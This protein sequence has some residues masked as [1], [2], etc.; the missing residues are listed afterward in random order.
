MNTTFYF[1]LCQIGAEKAVKAE[2]IDEYP[3]LRFCFSR[4]GFI[5]FK[6]SAENAAEIVLKKN[7]FTRLWGKVIGKAS[8]PEEL[9]QLLKEIPSDADVHFFDRDMYIPGEEPEGWSRSANIS[10][11]TDTSA[12]TAARGNL[13]EPTNI[14]N[15]R[16]L[17][18]GVPDT[19]A[20]TAAGAK[21]LPVNK[22]RRIYDVIFIDDFLV[23]AGSHIVT[24]KVIAEPANIPPLELPASSPSRA[25]LKL[26]EA[27]YRFKPELPPFADK[28]PS[29]LEV[30]CA[31][32]G[33]SSA[34]IS[35]GFTVTGIDPQSMAD[36]VYDSG[37]FTH[38]RKPARFVTDEE[39]QNVNP[40]WLAV[41]MSIPPREAMTE[42][43]HVMKALRRVHGK[44]LKIQAA[45][46][47]IKLNDWKYASSIPSV[48]E[49][50]E[51]MGFIIRE[52]MQL[53]F[54]QQ[55]FFIYAVRTPS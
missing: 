33:A 22:M 24:K 21:K 32:G 20:V 53:A 7:I 52:S 19:A 30:G 10:R 9:S 28:N 25:W 12:F 1:A 37:K 39:L 36:S 6:D 41:D 34:L 17:P 42:L 46:I 31:P 51:K 5:T 11:L 29:A 15:Q 26:E 27:V 40:H 38:I 35:R 48:F 13:N 50:I 16:I 3:S 45:F 54:N 2:V 23:F 44:N 4:P 47:T 14:D 8:S 55:E 18:C 43:S 49:S